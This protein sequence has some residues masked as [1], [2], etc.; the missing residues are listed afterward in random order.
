MLDLAE[1]GL[2]FSKLIT[3]EV[4]IILETLHKH[5]RD[6]FIIGGAV[7]D[8]LFGHQVG[9]FDIATDAVPTEIIEWMKAVHVKTKPI[10]GDFGTVLVIIGKKA[11]DV[12]TYRTETFNV[13]GEPP[14]V[15]FV[16]SLVAD[17]A[18][19][20]FRLNAIVY[21]P[22]KKIILDPHDGIND[23]QNQTI[24]MIGDPHIRLK[25][26]G[27]R[28]IRLARFLAKFDLT[29]DST[30]LSAVRSVG[31]NTK[32]RNRRAVRIELLKLIRV[33]NPFRGL[34][35]LYQNEIL[36]AIFPHFPF[37]PHSPR[38]FIKTFSLVTVENEITRIFGYLILM[39]DD[40]QLNESHFEQVSAVL[41]LSVKQ[42]QHF[43]RLYKSWKN[44]PM[45]TDAQTI[46]RWV[47]ATGINTSE[48]LVHI[49]F[50]NM[51]KTKKSIDSDSKDQYLKAVRQIVKK[52]KTG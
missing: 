7:R 45:N 8:F 49:Y 14:T 43:Q 12:S 18:R 27:L 3:P 13:H 28:I 30:L 4:S 26:D 48:V 34:E 17:L 16:K 6:A 25:E 20:D 40:S 10:G 24:N 37:S 31:R 35:L 22:K 44:F 11:F 50:L 32:S 9:D 15:V 51:L 38:E 19:R 2:E 23:I 46:K 41:E 29:A 36:K 21:D 42:E 5:D 33:S 52:F 1:K 47:R 39:A